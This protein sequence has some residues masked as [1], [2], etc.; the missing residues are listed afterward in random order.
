MKIFKILILLTLT[1]IFVIGLCPK[2]NF[3]KYKYL[4]SNKD[5][6]LSEG[7]FLYSRKAE[8]YLNYDF[9]S[10]KIHSSRVNSPVDIIPIFKIFNG[11]IFVTSKQK[12]YMNL[13][14][15]VWLHKYHL[16]DFEIE[17][18]LIDDQF[19]DDNLLIQNFNN[20]KDDFVWLF[21]PGVN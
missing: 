20:I 18:I 17:N 10:M 3:C 2:K 11:I 19:V 6:I 13:D 7:I 12:Y 15:L 21:I 9:R 8:S 5:S 4:N 14:E 16:K 1:F